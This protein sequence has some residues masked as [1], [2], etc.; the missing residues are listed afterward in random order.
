ML[1]GIVAI[2]GQPGLYKTVAETRN[3]I[4]VES[5]ANGK[6]FPAN[7]SAKISA[8]EDIA[9]FTETGELPLKE[10]LKR[11][12]DHEGGGPGMNP[13]ASENLIRKYFEI[14]VPGYVKEKVY[15]SDMKKI[16]LW[17]NILHEKGMLDFSDEDEKAE[18]TEVAEEEKTEN[19]GEEE[20]LS[21]E[22]ND[23][24]IAE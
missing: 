11:I 13:K 8:L 24:L 5:L 9:V 3:R 20:T 23:E 6:R 15:L 7:P 4:I 14:M 21:K 2:S 1:K 10:I 17:Y 18:E 19:A 22:S 12:Y 16:I